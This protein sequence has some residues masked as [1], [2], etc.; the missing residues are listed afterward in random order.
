MPPL[1]LI[2]AALAAELIVQPYLQSATPTSMWISWET[3]SGEGATVEWGEHEP[4]VDATE[5]TGAVGLSIAIIVHTIVAD[6]RHVWAHVLI[7][8]I[9]VFTRGR[10]IPIRIRVPY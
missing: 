10:T 1:L 7:G 4:F 9:A 8:V 6:F 3:D 2:Q 5:G